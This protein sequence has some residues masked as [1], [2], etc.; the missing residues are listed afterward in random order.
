[1]NKKD[2]IVAIYVIAI[3]LIGII[4]I[5]INKSSKSEMK[6][7]NTTTTTGVLNETN[8]GGGDHGGGAST[9]KTTTQNI[10]TSVND[11]TTNNKTRTTT[12]N[13]KTTTKMI[14]SKTTT[15]TTSK[16]EVENNKPTYTCPSGYT[17]N[18]N[19]CIQTIEATLRCQSGT[20]DYA[21]GKCIDLSTT[22]DSTNDTC[23]SGYKAISLVSFGSANQTKC[24]KL[25]DKTYKCPDDYTL[26]NNKCIKTIDAIL[27]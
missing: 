17:L 1:M 26:S 4:F 3:I 5:L 12:S 11:K 21:T 6:D 14:T 22:I 19:K 10:S 13:V 9:S 23:P 24:A 25:I 16:K 2:I 20:E 7:D 27:K 8:P 18:N 15:T